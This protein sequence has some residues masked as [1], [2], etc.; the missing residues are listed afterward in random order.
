MSKQQEYCKKCLTYK[1]E[2]KINHLNGSID[3][4]A[5]LAS[6]VLELMSLEGRF[7][8]LSERASG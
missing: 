8:H 4:K 7:D 6:S 1:R 2:F 5:I 3:A